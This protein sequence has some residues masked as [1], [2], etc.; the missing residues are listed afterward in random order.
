MTLDDLHNFSARYA[1]HFFP[2]HFSFFQYCVLVEQRSQ[3][4][5]FPIEYDATLKSWTILLQ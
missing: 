4:N 1:T 5:F 3:S 2:L